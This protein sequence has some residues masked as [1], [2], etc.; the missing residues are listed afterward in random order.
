MGEVK[1]TEAQAEYFGL[2]AYSRLS[3][4]M[5][6]NALL[7]CAN[8]SYQRAEEDLKELT[9]IKIS[10]SSLQRL[11]NQQNLELP[12]SRL[13]IQ[14]IM[15]DGGKVRLRTEEKGQPCEWKDYKA[16][17]L[18]GIQLGA[19]FLD[20]QSLIDWVNSQ[21]LLNPLFCL[22]DGHPGIWK[23]FQEISENQQRQEIIDWYHLKENLYKVGGSIKRL[24]QAETLLWEGKRA[25][26]I[27]LFSS[28]KN[29]QAK[30]FCQYL[31]THKNR[32]INYSYYQQEQIC[33]LGS[34][35]IESGIKQIGSRIKMSGA[36]WKSEN[37]PKIL[38]VRCAYL[39]GMLSH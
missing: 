25:E 35:S 22:G 14:E 38:S 5:E 13:G 11:V 31:E 8:N 16:V 1:I 4:K 27:Q 7:L 23:L 9:G 32:I 28:L 34:G 24:K 21:K 36:Q 18:N 10:H 2:K 3:P 12:S 29:Q 39:N 26:T 17:S 15:I 6:K 19:F 20:N 30:N 33:P 37:V